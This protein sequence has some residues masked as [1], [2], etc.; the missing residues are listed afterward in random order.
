MIEATP[1]KSAEEHL[2][3]HLLLVEMFISRA[4][5]RG[6]SDGWLGSGAEV[7]EVTDE[8]L[9]ARFQALEERTAMTAPT[10]AF[11]LMRK[12]LRLSISEQFVLWTLLAYELDPRLRRLMNYVA[13][14]VT[15]GLTVGTMESIL[16]FD[17]PAIGQLELSHTGTLHASRMIEI[18]DVAAPTCLRKI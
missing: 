11:D 12:R 8:A 16:Y 9:R 1:Y 3:D 7:P 5:R 15:T 10:L 14:E 6:R 17:S 2:R 4:I 13:T 18:E